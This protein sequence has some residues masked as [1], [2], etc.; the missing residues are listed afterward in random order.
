MLPSEEDPRNGCEMAF[1]SIAPD[2]IPA[3]AIVEARVKA[4][5]PDITI[6]RTGYDFDTTVYRFGLLGG[7][8]RT[9]EVDLSRDLLEDLRDNPH[10]PNS[11]YTLE[12]TSKLSTKV[13]EAIEAAG[14]LSF[15]DEA[16][17]YLLLQ[18]VVN[19]HKNGRTA[20]KYNSI[21]KNT[22]GNF[23]LWLR[24]ELSPEEKDSLIWSWGELVR[25]R[26]IAPTGTDLVSPDDLVKATE[27]GIASIEGRSFTEYEEIEVFVAKGEVFTA[28]RSLQRIFEQS[29]SKVIIIDPYADETVLDH[30]AALAPSI[31]V[32]LLTER[33][34]GQFKTAYQKLILQRG[35]VE[36]RV[37]AN[38][39]DRFIVLDD[40]KCFQLGSSINHLGKKS[41]VID[42][43]N[44]EVRDKILAEFA[45]AWSVGN[46][47]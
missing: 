46:P 24:A 12:I 25:L 37:A 11:R 5:S 28:F 32:Q 43:K 35:N 19:E 14:L 8:E 30:V 40:V 38:F 10:G 1:K 16:L 27:R 26:M 22:K 29:R 23:E 7:H 34:L 31:Q 15:S 17:K 6:D 39:H 21:G 9:A 13:R 45:N 44:D 3:F 18:F 47:L 41:T 36:V 42:V 2:Q 4:I 20:N 33:V